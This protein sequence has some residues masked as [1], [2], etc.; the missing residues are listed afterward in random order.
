MLSAIPSKFAPKYPSAVQEPNYNENSL[1]NVVTLRYLKTFLQKYFQENNK[2]LFY[3]WRNFY[4]YIYNHRI[5]HSNFSEKLPPIFSANPS[6]IIPLINP[7][8][9]PSILP[10]IIPQNI[11]GFFRK[12]H[13]N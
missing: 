6:I 7:G 4:F 9:A 1:K 11:W 8:I 3:D 10:A 2:S 13:N 12:F 5:S